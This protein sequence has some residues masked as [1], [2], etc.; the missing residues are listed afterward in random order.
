MAVTSKP[1]RA[2]GQ[3]PCGYTLYTNGDQYFER[4]VAGT[5]SGSGEERMWQRSLQGICCMWSKHVAWVY[6]SVW[7]LLST[8]PGLIRVAEGVHGCGTD[9]MGSLAGGFN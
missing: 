5:G 6:L 8:V 9:V 2:A 1:A 4:V 7:L 3:L